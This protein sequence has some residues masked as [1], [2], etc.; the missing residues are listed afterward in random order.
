[1]RVSAHHPHLH[2]ADR[3]RGRDSDI[4]VA[5]RMLAEFPEYLTEEQRV[6]DTWPSSAA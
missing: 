3:H 6:P 5:G 4:S 1:V 2:R